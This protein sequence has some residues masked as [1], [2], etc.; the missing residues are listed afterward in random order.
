MSVKATIVKKSELGEECILSADYHIA[1]AN[2]LR[3]FIF[4]NMKLVD[5]S[6]AAVYSKY[7]GKQKV[8]KFLPK[9]FECVE[10]ML[11]AKLRELNENICL[12][13]N[14][15]KVSQKKICLLEKKTI[16][17]ICAMLSILSED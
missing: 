3:H 9:N 14:M 5:V 16:G 2:G 8:Y 10:Y 12:L 7:Y 15:E 11:K 6:D 1:K 13:K 4:E 17:V